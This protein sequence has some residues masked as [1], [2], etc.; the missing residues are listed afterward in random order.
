MVGESGIIQRSRA[1]LTFMS[2]QIFSVKGKLHDLTRKYVFT[3][4]D[5]KL[6]IAYPNDD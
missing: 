2:T 4:D 6:L 5:L 3:N 1:V